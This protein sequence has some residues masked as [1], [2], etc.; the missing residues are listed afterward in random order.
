[1]TQKIHTSR[2]RTY[3]DPEVQGGLLRR[4]ALHW[5]ILTVVNCLGLLI[6]T[7][8]FELPGAG[9]KETSTEFFRRFLPVMIVSAALVP[10]FLLDTLKLTNRFAGPALR[11]RATLSDAAQ[12][13]S[14]RRLAF[15]KDDF[16][17]EMADD[18]NDLLEQQQREIAELRRE[19]KAASESHP[20]TNY[21]PA[22]PL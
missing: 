16:W 18:F 14:V 6:W 15:R 9:W 7:W 17:Q 2:T 10:A 11:F 3:V 20:S 4:I 8:L 13:R 22:L 19:I 5:V 21:E 12:G 1:M